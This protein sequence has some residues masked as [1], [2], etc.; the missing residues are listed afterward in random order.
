MCRRD[1]S[2]P[3]RLEADIIVRVQKAA[4][5]TLLLHIPGLA[6]SALVTC[7]AESLAM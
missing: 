6:D 1:K 7:G 3:F 5:F 4:E 2:D